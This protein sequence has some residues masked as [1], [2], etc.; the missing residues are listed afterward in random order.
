MTVS[1]RLDLRSREAKHW[2]REDYL[3][4]YTSSPPCSKAEYIQRRDRLAT[5]ESDKC[6][7]LESD[8]CK[9]QILT[10]KDGPRTERIKQITMAV[11][12][13]TKV[14]K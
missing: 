3:M 2:C 13:Q 5:S 9:R 4:R 12:P 1:V 8:V 11:D 6:D 10:C 14:F 7:T